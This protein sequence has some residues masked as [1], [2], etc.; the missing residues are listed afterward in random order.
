MYCFIMNYLFLWKDSNFWHWLAVHHDKSPWVPDHGHPPWSLNIYHCQTWFTGKTWC[1]H[2]AN[3]KKN[4]YPSSEWLSS[5]LIPL[6]WH[7]PI[8]VVILNHRKIYIAKCWKL[9]W[10]TLNLSLFWLQFHLLKFAIFRLIL[11]FFLL[12][13]ER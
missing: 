6:Y 10:A 8:R 2:F 11:F 5:S 3:L 9:F 1:H 13:F 4:N 7:Q 12:N